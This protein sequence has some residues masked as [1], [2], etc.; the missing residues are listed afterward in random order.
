MVKI[1]GKI[2]RFSLIAMLSIISFF[3]ALTLILGVMKLLLSLASSSHG[4]DSL[5][6]A[7]IAS[8]F[9]IFSVCTL[10]SLIICIGFFKANRINALILKA[11]SI[12]SSYYFKAPVFQKSKL[13][14]ALR[15]V[16]IISLALVFL[17]CTVLK[18]LF[19]ICFGF[20]IASLITAIV[21]KNQAMLSSYSIANSLIDIFAD[22]FYVV[23]FFASQ[24]SCVLGAF[25]LLVGTQNQKIDE[26]ERVIQKKSRLAKIRKREER[27]NN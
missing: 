3:S 4:V 21:T 11:N 22:V 7:S 20:D 23:I 17:A 26:L 15:I 19:T 6:I 13:Q 24:I 14:F 18:D 12:P 1:F 5:S 10:L 16:S 2:V 8:F 27:L 9:P 25:C